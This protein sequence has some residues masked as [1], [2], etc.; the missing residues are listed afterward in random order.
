MAGDRF[1]L[2][3]SD[4]AELKLRKDA[5][6]IKTKKTT[7]WGINFGLNGQVRERRFLEK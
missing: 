3:V 5:V 7:D 6:P 1:A 4:S 2:P